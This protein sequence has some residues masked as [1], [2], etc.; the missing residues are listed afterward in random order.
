MSNKAAV[1]ERILAEFEELIASSVLANERIARSLGLNV[2]DWQAFSVIARSE[3]PLTVGEI[4]ARTQLPT[5]STTRVLDRLEEEGFIDRSP[6]PHDRRRIVVRPRDGVLDRFNSDGDDN[7]YTAV[8]D[9]MHRIHE[10]F[11]ADEL[12]I[13]ER[14]LQAVNTD[15]Q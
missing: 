13:V 15:F 9:A 4:G 10:S 3:A 2:V 14:Y 7:P 11:S 8:K 6:D 12:H 1:T 5:S